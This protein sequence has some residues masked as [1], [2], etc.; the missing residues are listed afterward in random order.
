M[1]A[2]GTLPG[3]CLLA[4][5][6]RLQPHLLRQAVVPN[7]L[8][9]QPKHPRVT[10]TA[11]LAAG[12]RLVAPLVVAAAATFAATWLPLLQ[13][14]SVAELVTSDSSSTLRE[15]RAVGKRLGERPTSC[16]GCMLLLPAARP[17]LC[18][19]CLALPPAAPLAA[20]QHLEGV[21]PQPLLLLH[22]R[23]ECHRVCA[24]PEK[25]WRLLIV[26]ILGCRQAGRRQRGNT[27]EQVE[28]AM[29]GLQQGPGLRRGSWRAGRGLLG[30]QL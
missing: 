24:H 6:G 9:P 30:A 20:G 2:P 29:G 26:I 19:R 11:G 23:Q 21:P 15:E 18:L 12:P 13:G 14:S 27:A 4:I 3:L 8:H 16:H 5:F 22:A 17:H 7:V 1:H 28:K 25:L 10:A